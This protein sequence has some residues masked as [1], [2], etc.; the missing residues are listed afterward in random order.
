MNEY[1]TQ[2]QCDFGWISVKQN[3]NPPTV[4]AWLKSVEI[5]V[6]KFDR[7]KPLY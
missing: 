5:A 4:K 3:S 2:L 6:R 1:W 7:R